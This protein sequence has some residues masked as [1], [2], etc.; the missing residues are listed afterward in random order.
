MIWKT[1]GNFTFGFTVLTG[2]KLREN[3]KKSKF[4]LFQYQSTFIV[5]SFPRINKK[6][7]INIDICLWHYYSVFLKELLTSCI[8]NVLTLW[9]FFSNL[10]PW[11]NVTLII[12]VKGWCVNQW[13]EYKKCFRFEYNLKS[14]Q[15]SDQTPKSL[16]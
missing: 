14:S 2:K 8:V 11:K 6:M 15:L 1:R 4:P 13:K 3:K 16:V 10:K 7:N 12:T 9:I 5:A